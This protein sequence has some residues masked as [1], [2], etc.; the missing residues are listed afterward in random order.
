MR[1]CGVEQQR[2]KATKLV[3]AKDAKGAG[4]CFKIEVSSFKGNGIFKQALD[5]GWFRAYLPS[6]IY[7]YSALVRLTYCHWRS[8]RSPLEFAHGAVGWLQF[9]QR[10]AGFYR[11]G[12]LQLY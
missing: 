4:K 3:L 12:G 7:R 11:G 10:K 2:Y 1:Y 5:D 8:S 6:R 9:F